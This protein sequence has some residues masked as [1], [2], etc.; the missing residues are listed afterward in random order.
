[1]SEIIIGLKTRKKKVAKMNKSKR[2]G[3]I[4]V[5][6]LVMVGFMMA[7]MIPLV[8][9]FLSL[10]NASAENV[11]IGQAKISAR[12]I[13]N[14]AGEV[15]AQGNNSKKVIFVNFPPGVQNISIQSTEVIFTLD[16][17]K[18]TV[19]VLENTFANMT[20]SA[21]PLSNKTKIGSGLRTI[22]VESKGK[23]VEIGYYK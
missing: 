7:F 12:Q 20:E 17:T 23:Y 5:E 15:L 14:A 9:L 18:G 1:M 10:S 16:T 2:V 6:M 21:Y 13:G 3:Q 8:F 11:A 4:S 22:L 19:E